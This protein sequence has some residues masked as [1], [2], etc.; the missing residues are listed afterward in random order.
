MILAED[1][2]PSC[3]HSITDPVRA[4]FLASRRLL[5]GGANY[6]FCQGAT[7]SGMWARGP[8][9]IQVLGTCS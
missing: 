5:Y 7:A 1:S 3:L 9:A 6:G 4:E 2:C 8:L